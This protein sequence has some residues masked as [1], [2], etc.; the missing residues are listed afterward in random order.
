MKKWVLKVSEGLLNLVRRIM[1]K[2]ISWDPFY[3]TARKRMNRKALVEYSL[4]KG[5]IELDG[6]GYRV[7]KLERPE[8]LSK[9]GY[10]IYID[11]IL[12]CRVENETGKV[13]FPEN[14]IKN[15]YDLIE[16]VRKI[17]RN[18][19][20]GGLN[21]GDSFRTY[22]EEKDNEESYYDRSYESN[23]DRHLTGIGWQIF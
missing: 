10:K 13:Y 21:L 3:N 23:I 17:L 11:N 22:F 20:K 12:V 16:H 2:V 14:V 1:R 6:S 4:Q 15:N 9:N 5:A 8:G 19:S 18:L 7:L